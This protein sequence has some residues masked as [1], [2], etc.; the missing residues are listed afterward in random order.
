[1]II[2]FIVSCLLEDGLGTCKRFWV[3]VPNFFF[4]FFFFFFSFFL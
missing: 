2:T 1:M 3:F 4:F